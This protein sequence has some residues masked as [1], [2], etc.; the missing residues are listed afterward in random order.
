MMMEK[1]KKTTEAQSTQSTQRKICCFFHAVGVDVTS[2]NSVLS[3]P[4]WLI[5]F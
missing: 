4:L 1:L 3:V 5:A 2:K